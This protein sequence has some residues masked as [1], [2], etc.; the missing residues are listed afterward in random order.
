MVKAYLGLGSN[1]GD[2]E[3][4]AKEAIGLLGDKCK[5]LRISSL[6]ETE[7]VGYV[8][9][10]WFLNCVVEVETELEP[11]EL[12]SFLQSIEERLK[13][14]RRVKYGPRTIDLDI[15]FYGDMMIDSDDLRIPHPRLHERLFVLAPLSEISPD[16]V[17]PV[18]KKS[19]GE[20]AS[21]LKNPEKVELYIP[22]SQRK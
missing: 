15:L 3:Y 7:P 13:R 19:I 17:H 20:L 21:A 12:L 4:N 8:N 16:Y 1:M 14:T 18:L 5:I 11:R 2:R 9:Q 6:Y 10:D 22:G